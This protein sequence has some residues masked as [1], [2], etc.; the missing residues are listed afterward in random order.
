MKIW[1]VSDTHFGH[2]KL[3]ELAM[4]VVCKLHSVRAR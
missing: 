3:I 4:V 1:L 2:D